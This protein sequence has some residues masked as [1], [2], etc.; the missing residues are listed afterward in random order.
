MSVDTHTLWASL[1]TASLPVAMW[2]MRYSF[3]PHTSCFQ[4]GGV[5]HLACVLQAYH[6]SEK[7]VI[8]GRLDDKLEEGRA[9]AGL[10]IS[11]Q[12]CCKRC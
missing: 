10:G 9:L 3:A 5:T 7:A 11:F 12:V 8:C 6:Y 4:A 2:S 1:Q